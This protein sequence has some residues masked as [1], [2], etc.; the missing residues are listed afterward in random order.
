MERRG[1][2]R[3]RSWAH[4][5]LIAVEGDDFLSRLHAMDA[6]L[7]QWEIPYRAVSV[8]RDNGAIRICFSDERFARAFHVN[9]GGLRVPSDPL[10]TELAADPAKDDFYQLVER[11]IAN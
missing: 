5:V 10:A 11:K 2:E 4:Q 7:S 6:W 8:P 1:S 9:L 3:T